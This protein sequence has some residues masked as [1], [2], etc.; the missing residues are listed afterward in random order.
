MR[1]DS[2]STGRNVPDE[3]ARTLNWKKKPAGRKVVRSV[4]ARSWESWTLTASPAEK[5]S[6]GWNVTL[7]SPFEKAKVP[8]FVPVARPKTR[9]DAGPTDARSTGLSKS[10][11]TAV[12][13]WAR[14]W[15]GGVVPV[16][17]SGAARDGVAV[18]ASPR[19]SGRA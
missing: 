14:A 15:R 18:K 8:D 3:T 16:T 10:T 9:N 5:G 13:G 17:R 1:F 6:S 19:T 7:R 11:T 4:A 12:P 2:V